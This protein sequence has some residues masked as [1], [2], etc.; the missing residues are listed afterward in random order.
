MYQATQE[1]EISVL[2][3]LLYAYLDMIEEH[4]LDFAPDYSVSTRAEFTRFAGALAG[5]FGSLD[6]LSLWSANLDSI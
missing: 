4:G 2:A 3:G 5:K 1:F 6:F